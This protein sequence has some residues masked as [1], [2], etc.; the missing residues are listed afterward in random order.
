MLRERFDLAATAQIRKIL[1]SQTW[2]IKYIAKREGIYKDPDWEEKTSAE[3]LD[4]LVWKDIDVCESSNKYKFPK[5]MSDKLIHIV[6]ELY[7]DKTVY[8]SGHFYYPPTGYMGWH[9]NYKMPEERLYIT[10]A[11]EGG[12]SF[13]R[14]KQGN[15][16]VTDYDDAGLTIRRFTLSATRPYFWHCVGS[17]TDRYSFGYRL[18]DTI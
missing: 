13:F 7:P 18:C 6:K 4:S 15:E 11:S 3:Y 8:S 1:N 9:T 5:Q 16:V 2:G 10:L 14:Y 12:K 17:D